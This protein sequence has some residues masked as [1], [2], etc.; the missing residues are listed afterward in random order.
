VDLSGKQR[1]LMRTP[2]ALELDD[3]S[4]EGRA[5]V[6]HH[7]N[8]RTVRLASA[9]ARGARDLSWLDGSVLN[10]LSA[11]GRMLLLTEQ[12]EGSGSGAVIYLRSADGSPAIKLG[13][14]LG[15]AL[16]PDGQWVLANTADYSKAGRLALLPTG[17]GQPVVLSREGLAGVGW[18]VWHPDGK[19]IVFMAERQDGIPHVFV[20][21]VPSGKPV[22]L[23]PEGA[24]F[25]LGANPVSPNG[26]RVAAFHGNQVLLIPLDGGQV[27]V[28]PGL[29]RADQISQWS[30][31]SRSLYVWERPAKIWLCDV[32]TGQR[33]VWKEIP[34]EDSLNVNQVRMSLDGS[35]WAFYGVQSFSELYLIEGLR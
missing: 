12:G 35:T 17:P 30:A 22:P 23:G 14:G 8:L 10:D 11:D 3:I 28:A 20:Q 1:L 6:A 25:P 16:S 34:V 32:D 18:G 5:L 26:K 4:R 19:R 31:D 24:M 9:D 29:T 2:G 21:E 15:Q 7:N 27:T 13:D 33:R